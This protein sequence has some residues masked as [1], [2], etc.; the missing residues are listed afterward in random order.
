MYEKIFYGF[1]KQ[2][3][4]LTWDKCLIIPSAHQQ[5]NL[6]RKN[7]QGKCVDRTHEKINLSRKTCSSVR[8]FYQLSSEGTQNLTLLTWV[9]SV[10]HYFSSKQMVV[11]AMMSVLKC[12]KSFGVL[13]RPQQSQLRE[14]T[15]ETY[16]NSPNTN[17]EV[18]RVMQCFSSTTK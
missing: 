4:A 2:K 15:W 17:F 14:N 12:I 9:P 8:G 3:A 11:S 7:C 6:S 13:P 18:N 10:I 16:C 5:Q 1:G